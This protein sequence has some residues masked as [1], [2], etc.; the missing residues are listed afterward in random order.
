MQLR[1]YRTSEGDVEGIIATFVD[2]TSP[3]PEELETGNKRP[4]RLKNDPR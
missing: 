1:P 3:D 4:K 2:T